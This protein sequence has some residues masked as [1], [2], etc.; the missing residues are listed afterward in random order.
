[1]KTKIAMITGI[2][3]QDG[4][5]MAELLI[6][7][8]YTVVGI[9][10]N[11]K[12]LDH[13]SH[14]K[15]RIIFESG[16]LTDKEFI[17][18][19]V[20][21]YKPTE[22]YNFAAVSSVFNPWQNM[23]L[24]FELNAIC[25]ILFLE[26]IIEHSHKTKFFQASSAEMFDRNNSMPK[27]EESKF[28]PVN[29]YGFAKLLAHEVIQRV[30]KDKEIFAVS[31][32][33]FNHE[34]TRRGENFF[35]RA[36][37]IG[38]SKVKLG[39][40]EKISA[41]NLDAKRDWGYA[42]EY[43]EGI[44]K[45]MQ[46]KKPDD[47]VFATGKLHTTRDFITEAAKA[48]GIDIKWL[49]RGMKEIAKDAQGKIVVEVDK[50]LYRTEGKDFYGNAGKLNKAINWRAKTEFKKLV[51]IMALSDYNKLKADYERPRK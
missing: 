41:G 30:R 10:M 1:M 34:S 17:H 43:V 49:G 51:E 32:I 2:T 38:L 36:V 12:E 20:K 39:I 26:A 31:G 44:W 24:V 16:D 47:Y 8:K 42:P 21:K 23:S 22:I 37:S 29:P 11:K 50:K 27:T 35:T 9:V 5:Y 6:N 19:L 15:N 14:I 4:S 33:L 18:S 40:Q 28:G 48:L 3:G 46:A 7:K 45:A 13:V 25:P